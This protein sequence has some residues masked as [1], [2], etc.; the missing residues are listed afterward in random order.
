MSEPGREAIL[1]LCKSS[2]KDLDA[3]QLLLKKAERSPFQDWYRETWIA[4][5]SWALVQPR[6]VLKRLLDAT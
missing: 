3:L 5:R 1:A 6:T 2:L 4:E